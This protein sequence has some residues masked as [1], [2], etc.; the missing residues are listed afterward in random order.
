[1]TFATPLLFAD[2]NFAEIKL[3]VAP[4]DVVE[5]PRIYY[6]IGPLAP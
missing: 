4:P 3:C 2:C 5:L 6:P 1:M